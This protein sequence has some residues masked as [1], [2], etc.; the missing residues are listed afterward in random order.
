MG[1]ILGGDDGFGSRYPMERE[2]FGALLARIEMGP[3]R[4]TADGQRIEPEDLAR[5]NA[6]L[7][8]HDVE[9]CGFDLASKSLAFRS[10]V[11]R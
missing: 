2:T 8:C 7:A 1:M 11:R 6:L 5:L 9:I 3:V 4:V 10:L